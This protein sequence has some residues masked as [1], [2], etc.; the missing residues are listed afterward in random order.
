LNVQTRT[1]IDTRAPRCSFCG[2]PIGVYEP[3][4][5]IEDGSVRITSLAA[6]PETAG[7]GDVHLH[8]DCYSR[9]CGPSALADRPA[10]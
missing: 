5:E 4:A 7:T 3:M 2:E 9:A 8:F 6:D 1:I 10:A